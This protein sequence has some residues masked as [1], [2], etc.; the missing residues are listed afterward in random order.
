MVVD[1][2][3]NEVSPTEETFQAVTEELLHRTNSEVLYFT[4]EGYSEYGTDWKKIG[5]HY[6][7]GK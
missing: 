2:R 4:S 3:I 6:F 5:D 1:N 7:S